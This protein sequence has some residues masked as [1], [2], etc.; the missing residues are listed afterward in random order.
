MGLEP[1]HN[2]G[3]NEAESSRLVHGKPLV[4]VCALERAA[5]GAQTTRPWYV[6]THLASGFYADTANLP[7]VLPFSTMS[8]WHLPRFTSL[9]TRRSCHLSKLLRPQWQTMT[10]RRV[11]SIGRF[12]LPKPRSANLVHMGGAHFISTFCYWFSADICCHDSIHGVT[13][14]SFDG[15]STDRKSVV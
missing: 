7:Q 8:L 10:S 9:T 11:M 4:R 12:C 1:G 5:N 2:A 13:F 14:L 15:S 3:V 6:H